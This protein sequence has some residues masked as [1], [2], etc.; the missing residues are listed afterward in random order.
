MRS[1]SREPPVYVLK[2]HGIA[3]PRA[4]PGLYVVATP[5]GN[6]GDITVRA[7]EILAAV[8][9]IACE[10]TRVTAKLL[11]HYGIDGR[12][13]A[14][15]DH[16]GPRKRPGL[17][18]KLKDGAAIALVSDAGTPLVSDPGYR[19]VREALEAGVTVVPVPGPSSVLAAL[20]GSGLPT[21]A[22]MFA[23]F[24]PAKSA[25][26]RSRLAELAAI[27]ATL[28]VFEATSR[29]AGSLADMAA[30]LGDREAVVAREITKKFEERRAA[31][32]SELAASTA[33]AGPPKGEVVVLIAPPDK[34][35]TTVDDVEPLLAR[36]LE[37]ESVSRAAAKAAEA[38]GLP[39]RDLYRRALVLAGGKA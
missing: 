6:L 23:G 31:R 16:N 39:R 27:P 12:L 34:A 3:A 8:D 38:T 24:L 26:R 14:Y 1:G 35:A 33:A 32:L 4:E 7:L 9:V 19:L 2:G 25:A 18:A 17:I 29:L 10:D 13:T 20:A 15:H 22:F 28:V 30:C 5:I 36:L 37:T 21:D 11:R